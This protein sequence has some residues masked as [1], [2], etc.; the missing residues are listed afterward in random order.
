M[1]S[2]HIRIRYNVCLEI[3]D[4]RHLIVVLVFRQLQ[5]YS[6]TFIKKA[7]INKETELVEVYN[8][9]KDFGILEI[10]NKTKMLYM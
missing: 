2:R 8:W 9:I 5:S 1:D 4:S 7:S 3:F 6:G 10:K